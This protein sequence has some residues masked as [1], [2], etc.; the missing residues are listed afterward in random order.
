MI[1][2]N[3]KFLTDDYI[4]SVAESF[5]KQNS[6]TSIPVNIERV[7]ESNYRMDIVPIPGM[8]DLLDTDGYCSPDCTA[9][10][11]DQY[12]YE[13]IYN[14]YRF[15]LAHELGHR[16]LH[17]RYFSELLFDSYSEWLTVMDQID[18]WDYSKMEYQANMFAG[19]TLVPTIFLK[20]EFNKQLCLFEPQLDHARSNGIGRDA[21]VPTL[22]DAIAHELSIKFEV[23]TDVLCRRIEFEHLQEEI[24]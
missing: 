11:V 14:R 17:K 2:L 4:A 7:I 24:P 18:S 19:M 20:L 5:L 22:L 8:R 12:V 15:T 13:R 10:Y 23:S 21:Y 6:L 9:I 1:N 16:V 3:V